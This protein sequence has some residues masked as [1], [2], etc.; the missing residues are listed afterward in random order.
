MTALHWAWA[1]APALA[2]A[3][4]AAWLLAGACRASR[5]SWRRVDARRIR[6][7]DGDTVWIVDARGE[8][9]EK[10]RLATIDAPETY[11][12]RDAAELRAGLRSKAGL[13]MIVGGARAFLV[14][15]LGI[16]RY[17]RTLVELRE[18]GGPPREVGLRLADAGLARLW[19]P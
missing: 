1:H 13:E 3:A 17:G 10:L 5:A 19:R 9:V 11:R 15:R 2:A 4:L 8:A 14:R 18:E 12:A 7:I 6:V 16:D